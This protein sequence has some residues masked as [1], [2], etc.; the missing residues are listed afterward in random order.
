MPLAAA[1]K[2]RPKI[3]MGRKAIPP[4]IVYVVFAPSIVSTFIHAIS[5][6]SKFIPP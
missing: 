6:T 4:A 2:N 1:P 5:F 3:A